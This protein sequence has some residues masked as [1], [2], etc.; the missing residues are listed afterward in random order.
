MAAA[1][2]FLERARGEF[3]FEVDFHALRDAK[4]RGVD[5]RLRLGIESRA[6]RKRRRND[7][8][9]DRGEDEQRRPAIDALD[10]PKRAIHLEDPI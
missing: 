1:R 3:R 4:A 8:R 9:S 7:D 10:Q 6:R 2:Q 5:R